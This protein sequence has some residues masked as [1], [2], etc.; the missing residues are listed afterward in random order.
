[1]FP[2]GGPDGH[3]ALSVFREGSCFSK[4][5]GGVRNRYW[6]DGFENDR[7][8]GDRSYEPWNISLGLATIP[9]F[10]PA[11]FVPP[12]SRFLTA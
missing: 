4:G 7:F 2:S 1:M 6:S 11:L 10:I 5:E 12:G 8:A 9:L 3:L